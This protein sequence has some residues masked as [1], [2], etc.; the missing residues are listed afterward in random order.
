ML[1]FSFS[2]DDID[3]IVISYETSN[4]Q[5]TSLQLKDER[6]ETTDGNLQGL[7]HGE[8]EGLS[9]WYS[10]V[11]STSQCISLQEAKLCLVCQKEFTWRKKWSRCWSEVTTCSERCKAVGK[12]N[13]NNQ[14][15]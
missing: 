10:T 1:R 6:R 2:N 15:E 12:K 11:L 4:F 14:R 5:Q 9:N 3:L 8:M 13:K 7:R